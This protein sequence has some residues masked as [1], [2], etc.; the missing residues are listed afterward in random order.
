[1]VKQDRAARTRQSLL[2]AAAEIFAEQGFAPASLSAISRRAG[3][4]NG[5][6]HFH[7]SN[8]DS[9]ARA[10]EE[11]AAAA[12]RQVT[13]QAALGFDGPLQQLVGATR[14][15]TKLLAD[16]PVVRAGFALAADTAWGEGQSAGERV[17]VRRIW[18][19]WVGATLRRAARDGE[20]AEEVSAAAATHTVMAATVGIGVLGNGDEQ[21]FSEQMV[22]DFWDLLLPGLLGR[23]RAAGGDPSAAR[24]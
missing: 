8:K 12:L 16:D 4:S 15:L 9:L 23:G 2:H 14:V 20:L 11:E 22:N 13:E 18:Q 24:D 5:A 21:W 7:F 1:M 19:D 6:L 3:V 17:G 10:V